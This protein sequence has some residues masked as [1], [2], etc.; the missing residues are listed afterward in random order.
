[1]RACVEKGNMQKASIGLQFLR[2]RICWTIAA[3][4]QSVIEKWKSR[5]YY[6]SNHLK[7]AIADF[8]L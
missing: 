7:N 2:S 8:I 4:A 3:D 5:L 1:M 6:K